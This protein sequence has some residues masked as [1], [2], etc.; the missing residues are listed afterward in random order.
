MWY[1]MVECG[2]KQCD[3]CRYAKPIVGGIIQRVEPETDRWTYPMPFHDPWLVIIRPTIL[4]LL[5][6]GSC[7]VCAGWDEAR[8]AERDGDY[9]T[10]FTEYR[11]LAEGGDIEAL[12][13]LGVMYY[14]GF[15]VQLDYRKALQCFL[16]AAEQGVAGSQNNVGFMYARGEGVPQD[17]VRA[18]M[19][20]DI[21]AANGDQTASG[22]RAILATR[23]NAAQIEEAYRMARE[24]LKAHPPTDQHLTPPIPNHGSAPAYTRSFPLRLVPRWSPRAA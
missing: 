11:K 4:A 5:L 19:W 20:F 1:S 24:W 18:H 3:S 23:M 7:P 16:Q 22:N 14:N 15:G 9:A 8:A 2:A 13:N 17:L 12:H 6:V 10:A 21:A